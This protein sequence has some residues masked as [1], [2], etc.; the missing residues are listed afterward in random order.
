LCRR[1]KSQRGERISP[2]LPAAQI[3][4]RSI[5]VTGVWIAYPLTFCATF[6]LQARY[7]LLVWRKRPIEKLV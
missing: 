7:Y 2:S 6:V 4:S 1:K 3:L 5:G